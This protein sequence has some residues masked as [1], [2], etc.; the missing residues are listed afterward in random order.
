MDEQPWLRRFEAELKR[1]RVRV[2]SRAPS[3]FSCYNPEGYAEPW[4]YIVRTHKGAK[5]GGVLNAPMLCESGLLPEESA[6]YF[7]EDARRA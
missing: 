4:I 1:R 7:L 6:R 3:G 5:L 2:L